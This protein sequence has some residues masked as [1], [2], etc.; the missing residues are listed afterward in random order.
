MNQI[1][2]EK[3][4][5]LGKPV[6]S[7]KSDET[8]KYPH[9]IGLGMAWRLIQALRQEPDFLEKFVGEERK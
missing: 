5:Y 3:G 8:D 6:L 1:I 4:E 7:L 2:I 9:T